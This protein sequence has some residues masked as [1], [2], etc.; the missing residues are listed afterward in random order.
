MKDN[1]NPEK[2]CLCQSLRMF[3]LTA[4]VT[5]LAVPT[6]RTDDRSRI[7]AVASEGFRLSHLEVQLKQN[8]GEA[9]LE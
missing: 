3:V 9:Q 6:A 1:N 4:Q 8:K 2:K 5:W 7:T